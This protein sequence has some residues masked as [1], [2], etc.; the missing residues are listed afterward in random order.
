M[1][2]YRIDRSFLYLM[3]IYVIHGILLH[4]FLQ[5]INAD[6]I[7]IDKE[8]VQPSIGNDWMKFMDNETK[9]YGNG[10]YSQVDKNFKHATI[11]NQHTYQVGCY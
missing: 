3:A 4:L 2:D 5:P 9:S 10:D 11:I 8:L 1:S 7:T 6:G